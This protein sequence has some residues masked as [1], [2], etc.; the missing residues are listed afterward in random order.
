[1]LDLLITAGV[2]IAIP[3]IIVIVGNL[4]GALDRWMAK[5]LK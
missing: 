3:F 2:C 1:M 4:A 5:K